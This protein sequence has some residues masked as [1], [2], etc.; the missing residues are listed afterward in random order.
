MKL[1]ADTKNN[2]GLPF[3]NSFHKC[4]VEICALRSLQPPPPLR[5][6]ACVAHS[7]RS[8]RVALLLRSRAGLLNSK[9]T[10]RSL[11]PQT[12]VRFALPTASH[13]L[14][15][16]FATRFECQSHAPFIAY[17]LLVQNTQ[18]FL[19]AL[20]RFITA[21]AHTAHTLLAN[22]QSAKRIIFKVFITFI[23]QLPPC[24]LKLEGERGYQHI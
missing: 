8:A 7:L 17:F 2:G 23:G 19:K 6:G 1:R 14:A 4:L 21:N 9:C 22:A 24:P 15:C 11:R 20:L 10:S 3:P 5:A 12:L 13:S 16:R 18:L